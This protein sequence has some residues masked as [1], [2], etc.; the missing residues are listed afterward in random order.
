MISIASAA[1]TEVPCYLALIELGFDVTKQQSGEREFWIAEKPD[2]E[3][4]SEEGLCMLLGLAKLI[5]IRG[6]N[7]EAT[8]AEI[9]QFLKHFSKSVS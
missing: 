9:D 3:I 6:S 5:E 1:N 4:V 7:W 2:L 8:D